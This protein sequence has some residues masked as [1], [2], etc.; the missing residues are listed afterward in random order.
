MPNPENIK[1]TGFKPG[2]SGNPGG[3]P[4]IIAHIRDLARQYTEVAIKALVDIVKSKKSPPAARAF[5]ANSLLDRGYGKP[6]QYVKDEANPFD[7]LS[8]DEKRS[9]LEALESL[10]RDEGVGGS[11]TSTTH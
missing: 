2:R 6:T 10:E 1:A 8:F 3:R 4:K 9:L 11:G 7:A 5:A